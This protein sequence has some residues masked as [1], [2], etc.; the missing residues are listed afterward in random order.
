MAIGN[1]MYENICHHT[2]D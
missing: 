1:E 2:T